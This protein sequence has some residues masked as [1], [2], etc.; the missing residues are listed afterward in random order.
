MSLQTKRQHC[1]LCDLPRMPWAMINDFSEAVCRGCVNY[2]GA[3]RIELVLDAARQM[4]RLHQAA[5]RSHENGEVS[6]QSGSQPQPQSQHRSAGPIGVG[7]A[8]QQQHHHT[9]PTQRIGP[10]Q[11]SLMDFPVKMEA[12]DASVRPVRISHMAPHHMSMSNRAVAAAA[13]AGSSV[14]PAQV[15]GPVPPTLSVNL[16]RPPS[17]E[18][19]HGHTDGSGPSGIKR[20]AI[21]DPTQRPPLTRGES[22]PAAVSFVSERSSG[23]RDKHQPVRA[24]S[25]DAST[26]KPAVFPT[27]PIPAIAL[28]NSTPPI[29]HHHHNNNNNNNH[30]Q[31]Q[32][33]HHHHHHHQ[34]QQQLPQ[35]QQL[36]QQSIT[37]QPQ[38]NLSQL[39]TTTTTTTATVATQNSHNNN[40]NCS[41]TQLSQSPMANLMSITET[42]PPG[43]PR[44][45][46]SPPGP[47]PPRTA[48]RGSQHSP[49]SSAGS[50]S[51]RRSSGSR[52]VS[53]TT[54]TSSEVQVNQPLNVGQVTA[55][56]SVNATGISSN[57]AASAGGPLTV[58]AD[59][60][61]NPAANSTPGQPTPGLSSS[62]SVPPGSTAAAPNSGQNTTLKCTLCQER[63]EDTHFV[64]CPSVNHHKFCFPCSRESIKR[65]NGL[66]NEVY[67]PSGDRCPLANSTIPW[68][69]MQGEIS[70]ILGEEVK[71]KKERES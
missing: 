17:E 71:V 68:A 16:K 3:D 64:Q 65:Q 23:L 2:E 55:G 15:G 28:G 34:Q 47:P 66:G 63:L 33:H 49:N 37:V 31:H 26:F 4:K 40:N 46:P 7:V 8:G 35:P 54:V 20:S 70:T 43:S 5:K 10:P 45:G 56:G 32:N 51:G 6:Q 36:P 24:P 11:T 27:I 13:A 18:D 1:Y 62:A 22:L 50:S 29:H 61:S 9:Y 57:A 42:L 60:V 44:N 58:N 38:L 19:D 25:F 21:D 30:H 41:I 48:S 52:H 67:C 14:S 69:F 12:H 59:N 53:S 39:S